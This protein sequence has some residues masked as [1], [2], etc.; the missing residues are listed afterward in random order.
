MTVGVEPAVQYGRSGLALAPSPEAIAAMRA[1]FERERHVFLPRLFSPELL[2]RIRSEVAVARFHP[3]SDKGIG[4]ELCMENNVAAQ[5][6]LFLMN[7]PATI[8]WVRA[9]TGIEQVRAFVGRVYTMQPGKTHYDSWH[10]DLSGGRQVSLT[11]NLGDPYQG[12][13]LQMRHKETGEVL[14]DICN[15]GPGDAILFA[16]ARGLQHRVTNVSGETDKTAFSGWF[17]SVEGQFAPFS[18]ERRRPQAR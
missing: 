12:G 17:T 7:H 5:R 10:D 9:V 11:V 13:A 16:I 4:A 8:G 15:T 18:V 1:Q 3:R 14:W 2:E 6:M